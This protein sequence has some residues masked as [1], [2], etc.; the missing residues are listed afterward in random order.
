LHLWLIF[1][2][3]DTFG[4]RLGLQLFTLFIITTLCF[5]CANFA[6]FAFRYFIA[7]S[8]SLGLAFHWLLVRVLIATGQGCCTFNTFFILGLF[9]PFFLSSRISIVLAGR[10]RL[11]TFQK[12]SSASASFLG[13][14]ACHRISRLG[15]PYLLARRE[16]GLML[17][18]GTL[19]L[20]DS[21]RLERFCA[22]SKTFI[23]WVWQVRSLWGHGS[24]LDWKLLLNLFHVI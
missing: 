11:G 7:L 19:F 2:K 15:F 18:V 13:A 21:L 22:R 5:G 24:S 14:A 10:W 1:V 4:I 20:A 17:G 6:I 16:N 12:A 8:V 23:L 3:I 9:T